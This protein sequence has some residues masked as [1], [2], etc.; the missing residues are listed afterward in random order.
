MRDDPSDPD[1]YR[2]FEDLEALWV[3]HP[4]APD[5]AVTHAWQSPGVAGSFF[6]A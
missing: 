3:Q 1:L 2:N 4:A 5:I 6:A